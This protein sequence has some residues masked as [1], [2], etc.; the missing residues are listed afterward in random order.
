MKHVASEWIVFQSLPKKKKRHAKYE[1][2]RLLYI[3]SNRLDYLSLS[4]F[5]WERVKQPTCPLN[6]LIFEYFGYQLTTN[7]SIESFPFYFIF[8]FEVLLNYLFNSPLSSRWFQMER[9]IWLRVERPKIMGSDWQT[10]IYM[11]PH[12]VNNRIIH[13]RATIR[14]FQP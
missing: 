12:S 14:K 8:T 3:I 10:T 2:C 9:F 11:V 7:L 1:C 13:S 4:L 6:S 5:L